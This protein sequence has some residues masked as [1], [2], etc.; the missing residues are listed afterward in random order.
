MTSKISYGLTVFA[1]AFL[2]FGLEPLIAKRILP[3]F[4]GAAAVWIVCLLFFQIVLLL[5]YAYAHLLTS[6]FSAKSQALVHVVALAASLLLLPVYPRDWWA[7]GAAA[8]PTFHILLLL[9]ATV[10]LPYLLLSATSPLLQRWYAEEHGTAPYRFYALSNLGSML[11]L[12][13]YPVLVEPWLTTRHQALAWS[14]FYAGFVVICGM[15]AWRG[16]GRERESRADRSGGDSRP[17]AKWTTKLAW[18]SLAACGSA[19]LL[20]VTNHITQNVASV[21]FLWILPLSL[22]LLSFILCFASHAWYP[23]SVFLRLL[24]VALG[25]M[26]Y[27][28][29]PSFSQLPIKTAIPLFCCGLFIACMFCHGELARLKPDPREL[30]SFYLMIAAGGAL[31]ALFVAIAAPRIFSGFYELHVALGLC[32]VLIVVVHSMDPDS[33]F[34]LWL[35]RPGGFAVAALAVA[36]VASLAV[37]AHAT[38]ASARISVRNFY[39]V[40]R[41]MDGAAPN[42]AV[43]SGNTVTSDSVAGGGDPNYISL[44]NGTINHGV[45]FLAPDRRNWATTYYGPFS[46]IGVALR[47]AGEN[48]PLRVGVI[49]LG[50]GTTAVYGR[51]GDQF[52][53]YEINPLVIQIAQQQFTFLK[54][55][56]AAIQIVQGDARISLE[57]EPPQGFDVL[58]VDAFSGDSIPV[59][60]LT[61]EAFELYFRQLKPDGVLAVHISNNYLDL[62]P[63]VVGAAANLGKEAVE[64]VNPDDHAKGISAA[65]WIL[66]GDPEGFEGKAEIEGKGLVMAPRGA[67]RMWTDD[68]SNLFEA[69]R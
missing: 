35:R 51:A 13:S 46:G 11:A 36:I 63:V 57:S 42:V 22:Y 65:V 28:L 47:A 59:H 58:A 64:I 55:S 34:S 48:G 32:A 16:K 38:S 1:G 45:E 61:R 41:V 24:G 62:Q 53:Y 54:D 27:A 18:V 37:N 2:L 29:S 3:W 33:L 67:N 17:A 26:T 31:G 8:S 30:T 4:G 49:G 56:A 10:G 40:L 68:F 20:S 69:L 7:N 14:V 44:V 12:I 50:A 6:R 23:R 52:T 5:G 19:L 15:V 21:P 66:V 25:G 39:G 9:S 43:V 60:L